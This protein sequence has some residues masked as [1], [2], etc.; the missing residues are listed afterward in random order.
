MGEVGLDLAPQARDPDVHGAVIG[1]A[2]IAFEQIQQQV[3]GK[4]PV[5][6]LNEDLDQVELSPGETHINCAG[7]Q[8][9]GRSI[10][11]IGAETSAFRLRGRRHSLAPA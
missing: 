7:E 6:P 10:E 5:R 9:S 8:A 3:P 11:A 4:H 1:I 2:L